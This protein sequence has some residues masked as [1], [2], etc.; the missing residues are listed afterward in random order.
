MIGD[1]GTIVFVLAEGEFIVESVNC[2][3]STV[4]LCDFREVD[5]ALV[6]RP[7]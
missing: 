5:L 3:G 2:D 6:Q 7:A 4:W 1:T